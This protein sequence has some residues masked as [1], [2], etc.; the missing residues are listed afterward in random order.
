[1]EWNEEHLNE[2]EQHAHNLM[3]LEEIS[4]IMEVDTVEFV[5]AYQEKGELYKKIRRGRLLCKSTKQA[6]EIDL[7]HRGHADAQKRVY[8]IIKRIEQSDQSHH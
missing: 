5:K 8:E 7:S 6:S 3:T 1:M 4:E 2:I